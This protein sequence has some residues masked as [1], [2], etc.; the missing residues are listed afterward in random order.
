VKSNTNTTEQALFAKMADELKKQFNYTQDRVA[1]ACRLS[2]AQVS[3]ILSGQRSPGASALELLT[4]EYRSL[5]DPN[6]REPVT[7]SAASAEE[8]A[9]RKD[10]ERLR[11]DPLRWEAARLAV[12]A[13]A[14]QVT[15]SSAPGSGKDSGRQ[16]RH[17]AEVTVDENLI[18]STREMARRDQEKKV[19][20]PGHRPERPNK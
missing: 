16:D 11:E 2:A 17:E 3:M 8:D 20:A 1:A 5:T 19:K 12:Q 4:R 13:L 6:Y 15:T 9:L 7:P 18:Q 10:M 14:S